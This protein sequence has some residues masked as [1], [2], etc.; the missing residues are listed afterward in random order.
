MQPRRLEPFGKRCGHTPIGYWLSRTNLIA[1]SSGALYFGFLLL[2]VEAQGR[3]SLI[4]RCPR[5]QKV[6]LP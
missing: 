6:A 3:T 4:P 2:D 5:R 1:L